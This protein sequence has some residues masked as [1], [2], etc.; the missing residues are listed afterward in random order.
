MHV[1]RFDPAWREFIE[2]G[3]V[4]EGRTLH[5]RHGSQKQEKTLPRNPQYEALRIVS[6]D[7]ARGVRP[8]IELRDLRLNGDPV[9]LYD[10]VW[11]Q[12]PTV[13]G[14]MTLKAEVDRRKAQM[15]L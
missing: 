7:T 11:H 15:G 2:A 8:R 1:W 9:T 14:V 6:H 10:D 12:P 13:N 5:I 4:V 3:C